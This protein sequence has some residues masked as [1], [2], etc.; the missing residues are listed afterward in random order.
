[1]R[2]CR[3][4]IANDLSPDAVAAMNRN[5]ELN[6]LGPAKI[7]G[8]VDTAST[9][10]TNM[11]LGK[12]RVNQGDAWYAL[13]SFPQPPTNLTVCGR[14]VK[15]RSCIRTVPKKTGWTLSTLTRTEA[16]HHLSMRLSNV[17]P[18]VACC[19]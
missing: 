14:N 17:L 3:H 10:D 5:I 7:A 11:R 19:A 13:P 2:P 12:V 1:M 9:A 4:V 18:T 16:P 6:G 8:A 15:V